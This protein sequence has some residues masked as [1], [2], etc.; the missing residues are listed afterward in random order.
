[1]IYGVETKSLKLIPDER[2]FLMEILRSD[3]PLFQKFGQVYVS[4]VYPGVIKGWHY[5]RRQ[6]DF[7]AVIQGM[8]KLV[9]Y[10]PRDDSPTC[11]SVQELFIGELSPQLVKIPPL[12]LHGMKGIGDRLAVFINCPTE[13]Y[14]YD[15]PDE[16]R[17]D[18]YD[19]TIPYD[20][21]IREH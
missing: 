15:R 18:P 5:H 4:A 2:G 8:A 13:L 16:Y 9:L 21:G 19:R 3:D 20:W 14:D 7:L 11:G 6:T 10:D 1:M 17:V 12:V